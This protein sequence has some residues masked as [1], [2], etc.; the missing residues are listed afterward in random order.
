MASKN[1]AITIVPV[2]NGFT[3]RTAYADACGHDGSGDHVFQ[4][5]GELVAH[6]EENL[7]YRHEGDLL[8]DKPT[9]S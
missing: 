5:F 4:S 9:G 6:L 8:A 2:A 1:T 3:V 7:D